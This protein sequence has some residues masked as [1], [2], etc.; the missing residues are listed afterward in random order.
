MLFCSWSCW[1]SFEIKFEENGIGLVRR[2]LF[3]F[4]LYMWVRLLSVGGMVF[5]SLLLFR[6]NVLMLER[7]LKE[8]GMGLMNLD[9]ESI[10]FFNLI[11]F[12]NDVG[13]GIWK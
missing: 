1:L 5:V 2:L 8:F 6:N 7:E 11:S 10:K 12:F 4:N 9:F 13:I 3:S